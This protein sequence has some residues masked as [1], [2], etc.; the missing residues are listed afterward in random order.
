LAAIM[1]NHK[2]AI[3]AGGAVDLPS[4]MAEIIRGYDFLIAVNGGLAH[5]HR[6]GLTPNLVVGDFDSAP[7]ELLIHY[8]AVPKRPFPK[9]KDKS[10]LELALDEVPSK[11]A[12]LFGALK[13]RSDH[14][15]YHLYLLARYPGKLWIESETERLVAINSSF[16]FPCFLEQTLSFFPFFGKA[17]GVSTR[18][19][20]WEL[21]D[22]SFDISHMSLSNVAIDEKVTINVKS[23]LLILILQ[24]NKI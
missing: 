7:P 16:T 18:G 23:G 3:L 5:C 13:K 12:T 14:T 1:L 19:L 17:E 8:A 9:D 2:V 20:R 24:K 10:D 21:K 11:E 22:A 4:H 15:L 6:M